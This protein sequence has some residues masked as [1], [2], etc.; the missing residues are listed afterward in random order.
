MIYVI[1]QHKRYIIKAFY[2]RGGLRRIVIEPEA[3]KA[4]G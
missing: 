2:K 4:D 3:G 1:I